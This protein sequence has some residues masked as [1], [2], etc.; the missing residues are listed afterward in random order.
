MRASGS[1]LHNA[2]H[3]ARR[4]SVKPANPPAD[5][6][7]CLTCYR[8]P[9]AS[10]LA[11]VKFINYAVQQPDVW[12]VTYSDLVRVGLPCAC[13]GTDARC[14]PLPPV[15]QLAGATTAAHPAACQCAERHPDCSLVQL[16]ALLPSRLADP[17]DAEPSTQGPVC[18]V[19]GRRLH[20][21]GRQ[22][23]PDR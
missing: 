9:S 18:P 23:R 10:A 2:S 17:V 3:A 14:G 12:F 8:A 6:P 13:T 7:S 22:S 5:D 16:P 11:L 19:V 4:L 21:A 20:G 1:I 15:P